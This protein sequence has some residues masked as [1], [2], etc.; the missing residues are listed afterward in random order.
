MNIHIYTPR[1]FIREGYARSNG[2]NS[3]YKWYDWNERKFLI[4]STKFM[5]C[6]NISVGILFWDSFH[7]FLL[8]S[9]VIRILTNQN[10]KKTRFYTHKTN[11]KYYRKHNTETPT[12][13]S[14][15]ILNLCIKYLEEIDTKN[16]DS[17]KNK[18]T[19]TEN[20]QKQLYLYESIIKKHKA[21]DEDTINLLSIVYLKINNLSE[22]CKQL[23]SS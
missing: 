17:I 15:Y 11:K 2:G 3:W 6:F 18:L 7:S 12:D 10:D 13:F 16:T 22:I 9:V 14:N 20:T 5:L 1:K 4:D 19:I 21:I 23:I 8:L